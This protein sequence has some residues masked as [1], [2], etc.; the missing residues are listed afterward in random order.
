MRLLGRHGRALAVGDALVHRQGRGLAAQCD[1]GCLGR[2]DGPGV[3]E[4]QFGPGRWIE[5]Q[6][7]FVRQAGELVL[8]REAGDV[9]GR[10]HRVADGL[11]REV[12]GAG[13][14][15]ALAKVDRDA[16]RLVAVALDVLQLA[17]ARRYRQPAALRHLGAGIAGAHLFRLGE[18][19]FDP[20]LE[21]FGAVG[22]TGLS[23]RHETADVSSER[24]S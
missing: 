4:V 13:I 5:G 16:Q 21:L 23:L 7:G 2:V 19:V 8:G 22:E 11:G 6:V 18:G 15:A 14:A 10:T 9:I 20:L 12:R 1:V 24:P 3:E 17:Q